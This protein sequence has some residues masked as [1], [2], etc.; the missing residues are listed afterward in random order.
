MVEK[1][2]EKLKIEERIEDFHPNDMFERYYCI[3]NNTNKGDEDY[4]EDRENKEDREDFKAIEYLIKNFNCISNKLKEMKGYNIPLES[5]KENAND[6]LKK[7]K[8]E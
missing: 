2:Y 1:E 3:K 7:L 6:N 4:E 8:L 5:F